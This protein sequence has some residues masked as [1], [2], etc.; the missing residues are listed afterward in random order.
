[1]RT[2]ASLRPLAL[3]LLRVVLGVLLGYDGQLKVFKYGFA[4]DLFRS[5]Y[6][7]PLAQVI[8]PVVSLLELI[9]GLGLFLGLFTRLLG[10]IFALEFLA[11]A[12]LAINLPG[13]PSLQMDFAVFA[14]AIVLA[15]HGAGA[16]GLDRPGFPWE[17]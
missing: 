5:H 17:P 8:G 9:G 1:M 6:G 12:L 2:L 11:L 15:T 16:Y 7:L 4:I 10:V 13:M 14:G 3:T